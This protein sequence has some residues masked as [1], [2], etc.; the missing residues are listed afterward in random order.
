MFEVNLKFYRPYAA[1]NELRS[2]KA[3]FRKLVRK[4][5]SKFKKRKQNKNGLF[6]ESVIKEIAANK[7]GLFNFTSDWV[8]QTSNNPFLEMRMSLY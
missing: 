4:T 5:S 6:W 1:Q 7:S 3:S 8:A 2:V